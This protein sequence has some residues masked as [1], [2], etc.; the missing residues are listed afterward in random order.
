MVMNSAVDSTNTLALATALQHERH[1]KLRLQLYSLR[2]S[3]NS[4][5]YCA[6][7][8]ILPVSRTRYAPE[9]GRTDAANQS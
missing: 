6:H 5:L 2:E 3:S 7:F 1:L 9:V 8:D 4:K